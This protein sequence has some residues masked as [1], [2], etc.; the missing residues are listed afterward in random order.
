MEK[1]VK[2]KKKYKKDK[3]V[4][5]ALRTDPSLAGYLEE[6][7]ACMYLR[8]EVELEFGASIDNMSALLFWEDEEF[9]GGE[10]DDLFVNGYYPLV[11]K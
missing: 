2:A 9:D 8:L 6:P 1:I 5:E 3:S 4:G 10:R 11:Q 7:A